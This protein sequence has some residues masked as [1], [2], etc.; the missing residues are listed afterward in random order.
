ME[1]FRGCTIFLLFAGKLSRLYSNSKYLIKN[2]LE[3]LRDWRLIRESRESFPPR[4]ICIIRYLLTTLYCDLHVYLLYYS[5]TKE[6][7]GVYCALA[8]CLD[9]LNNEGYADVFQVVRSLREQRPYIL[10]SKVCSL[11][12]CHSQY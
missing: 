6:G 10:Y 8:I 2:S 4:T 1:K 5:M 7:S 9:S 11:I 3:N 12:Y